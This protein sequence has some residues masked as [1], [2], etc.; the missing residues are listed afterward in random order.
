MARAAPARAPPRNET[1]SLVPR[2]FLSLSNLDFFFF[3]FYFFFPPFSARGIF[4]FFSINA[5]GGNVLIP[6]SSVCVHSR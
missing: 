3:F 4:E 1:V 6:R 5:M 2:L